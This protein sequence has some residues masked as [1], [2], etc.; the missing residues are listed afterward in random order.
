MFGYCNNSA[1]NISRGEKRQ[2]IHVFAQIWVTRGPWRSV[3]Y[4][5]DILFVRSTFLRLQGQ[6]I[7]GEP[8]P[9]QHQKM[10]NPVHLFSIWRIP[11]SASKYSS[12]NLASTRYS[13]I[14][15]T[16]RQHGSSGWHLICPNTVFFTAA[17]GT[18]VR[19][20]SRRTNRNRHSQNPVQIKFGNDRRWFFRD[21]L[22]AVSIAI[23]GNRIEV[24]T[25][26][27]WYRFR[28]IHQISLL[29]LRRYTLLL[30]CT[31]QYGRIYMPPDGINQPKQIRPHSLPGQTI[32]YRCA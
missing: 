10:F 28:D 23:P 2:T 12:T 18:F 26:V 21:G 9:S 3:C 14:P 5:A 16:A 7:S 22:Y 15:P 8:M 32:Y 31:Q 13:G 20:K 30:Y 29:R 4:E 6:N 24:T 11:E 25:P 17:P 1:F 19:V 27:D